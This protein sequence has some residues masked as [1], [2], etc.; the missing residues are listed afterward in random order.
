MQTEY[1]NLPGPHN[2]YSDFYVLELSREQ[3]IQMAMLVGSDYTV[4]I[5]GVGPVTAIEILAYFSE[6]SNKPE[7]EADIAE[8]LRKF[9]LWIEKNRNGTSVLSRKVKNVSLS[10]G[11]LI[12]S[13]YLC[14]RH[15]ENVDTILALIKCFRIGIGFP[16]ISVIE[17]YLYPTVDESKESFT[18]ATPD[19]DRIRQYMKLK[20]G[21]KMRRI[22]EILLPVMKRQNDRNVSCTNS[23][24]LIL[25]V[26]VVY[27]VY[28]S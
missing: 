7:T 3:L 19:L 18:W 8:A 11:W 9:K 22:D 25:N 26:N 21:W 24:Y 27:A 10:E 14:V 28:Y 23:G 6:K 4:G 13:Y 17:A 5:E 2:P 20:F 16:N 15:A 12:K 1:R